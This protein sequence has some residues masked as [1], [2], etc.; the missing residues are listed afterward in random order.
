ML[1]SRASRNPARSVAENSPNFV[2]VSSATQSRST[3]ARKGSRGLPSS[4]SG[5]MPVTHRWR[6]APYCCAI[7]VLNVVVLIWSS[8]G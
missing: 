3:P 6:N 2:S 1:A 8:A 7:S 5:T 4:S